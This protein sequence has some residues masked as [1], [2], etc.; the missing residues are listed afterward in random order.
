MQNVI[1]RP[2][3]GCR[4]APLGVGQGGRRS[5][6][7]RAQP[8][9]EASFPALGGGGS[10]ESARPVSTPLSGWGPSQAGQS[11]AAAKP[12]GMP[13]ADFPALQGRPARPQTSALA[14]R[15]E[16]GADGPPP[17]A[18]GHSASLKAANKVRA[19][20]VDCLTC[21][22][23]GMLSWL[24]MPLPPFWLLLWSPRERLHP[25][26]H[27]GPAV[28]QAL[29]AKI[30]QRVSEEAYGDITAAAGQFMAGSLPAQ[31]FFSR[32]Q[33]LG[34]S[35]LVPDMG[36][37]LQD[38]AK[39]EALLRVYADSLRDAQPSNAGWALPA[40]ALVPA[41][42]LC[43][44]RSACCA[45]S[46]PLVLAQLCLQKLDHPVT[47]RRHTGLCMGQGHPATLLSAE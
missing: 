30:R 15:A 33:R 20:G 6:P 41:A 4:L 38:T 19:S 32:M 21:W 18:G 9:N 2:R 35:S 43:Q 27:S 34:I 11:R 40:C 22:L 39:R 46:G 16:P 3:L 28:L 7:A 17:A 14:Q 8:P 24:L 5:S 36:A 23:L 25:C 47:R 10:A 26:H 1:A 45:L 29:L 42:L 37:L 13:D 12:P 31:A 44:R